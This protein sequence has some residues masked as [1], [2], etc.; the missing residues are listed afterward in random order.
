MYIYYMKKNLFLI[1][2]II[3][4][5]IKNEEITIKSNILYCKYHKIRK[6]N[7]NGKKIVQAILGII[8]GGVIA[9]N[10]K[11]PEEAKQIGVL[12]TIQSTKDL[13]EAVINETLENKT[14]QNKKTKNRTSTKKISELY[15]ILEIIL[16][17]Q[18]LRAYFSKILEQN[19]NLNKKIIF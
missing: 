14:D 11:T 2:L 7:Y 6:N 12:I 9:M 18:K 4:H 15:E 1:F 5:N 19:I 16:S 3:F 17:N 10:E 13:I 8:A